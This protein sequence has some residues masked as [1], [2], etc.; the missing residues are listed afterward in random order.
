MKCV[1]RPELPKSCTMASGGDDGWSKVASSSGKTQRMSESQIKREKKKV[2]L[3][4]CVACICHVVL[5]RCHF[6]AALFLFFITQ[7]HHLNTLSQH[8]VAF[9]IP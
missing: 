4:S 1:S 2:C 6:C 8:T 7:A 5:L 9:A 3:P